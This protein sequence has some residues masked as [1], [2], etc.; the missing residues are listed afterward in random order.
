[1]P[2][3]FF[4]LDWYICKETLFCLLWVML[5]Q[6]QQQKKINYFSLKKKVAKPKLLQIMFSFMKGVFLGK[7]I[8][9]ICKDLMYTHNN[10][11]RQHHNPHPCLNQQPHESFLIILIILCMWKSVKNIVHLVVVWPRRS[12]RNHHTWI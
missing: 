6:Q 5:H 9:I 7:I 2:M 3:I 10:I 11:Q 4:K 12:R 1:M 8:N